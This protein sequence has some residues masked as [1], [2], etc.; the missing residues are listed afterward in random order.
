MHRL[1]AKRKMVRKL[2]AH[3]SL[4]FFG[5][6]TMQLGLIPAGHYR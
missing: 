2:L 1:G 3:L 5:D 4:G 6:P